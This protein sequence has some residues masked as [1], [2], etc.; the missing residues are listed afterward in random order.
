MSKD[1]KSK[2]YQSALKAVDSN[3]KYPLSE[4]VAVLY[5]MPKARFNETVEVTAHLGVDPKQTDQTVRGSV[6]LPHG[7]GQTIKVLAFTENPEEAKAAGAE[8]VGLDD[9]IKK[10][11]EGWIDFDVA[12]ATPSAMKKVRTLAK[13]LGPKGLMPNPKTGTVADDLAKVIKEVKAGRVDFR[14]DKG[15]NVAIVVGKRSFSE[16]E[17]LENARVAIDALEKSKSSAIKGN[18]IESLS[19]SLTMSP[20]VKVDLKGL[21]N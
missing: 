21:Q 12:V 20:S 3:K 1:K 14:M 4:A 5:Q 9:L 10:I 13:I 16:K 18:F 7:S 15:A 6:G 8:H 11:E 2:R 19:I 17:I